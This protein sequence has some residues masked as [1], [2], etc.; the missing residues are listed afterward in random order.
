MTF[1]KKLRLARKVQRIGSRNLGVS[2]PSIREAYRTVAAADAT[3]TPLYRLCAMV[4][5]ETA[6]RHIF[7]CDAGSILCHENVTRA[8]YR[9]LQE[10]V[11]GGGVSNGVSYVQVT[12]G[13]FLLGEASVNYGID[14]DA[15]WRPKYNLRWGALHLNHLVRTLGRDSGYNAYNGDPTGAYGRDLQARA[16]AW[17]NA[18]RG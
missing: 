3:N 8:R 6:W 4:E 16:T 2:G 17:Y 18:L 14:G 5:K 9:R 7:G 12:Y 1:A 13:G 11:R 10:H 15:L